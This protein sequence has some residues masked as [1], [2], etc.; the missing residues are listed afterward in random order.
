MLGWVFG[1][2]N[3]L[4]VFLVPSFILGIV[5]GGYLLFRAF[6]V[7]VGYNSLKSKLNTFKVEDSWAVVTGS[8]DGIGAAFAQQLADQ[9]YNIVLLAR[10]EEKLKAVAKSITTKKEIILIDFSVAND[11]IYAQI[12]AKLERL[13]IGVLVNN[14]G[15]SHDNPEKFHQIKKGKINELINI[16]VVATTKMIEI[17]LPIMRKQKRGLI[18]NVSSS[19]SL[20]PH[21]YLSVY[22]ATKAYVNNL[23]VA[24]NYEYKKNGIFVEC[25]TPYLIK[26]KLS[27]IQRASKERPE[28]EHY[29]KQ[30]LRRVGNLALHS[31][32]SYHEKFLF[33]TGL[34]PLKFLIP[35]TQQFLKDSRKKIKQRSE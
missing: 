15:I 16:N 25:I 8:S 6:F 3:I 17:V 1:I 32:Y 23:S 30:A 2:S 9:G 13:D 14:V 5:C 21:P 7:Y 35:K 29:V 27:K 31:G 12:G 34:V 26:T 24:L 20:Y 33:T 4:N 10:N 11:D 18:L 19:S 28:P 22:A